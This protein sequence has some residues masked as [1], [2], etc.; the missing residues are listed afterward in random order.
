MG[1]PVVK[2]GLRGLFASRQSATI[3]SIFFVCRLHNMINRSPNELNTT[4]TPYDIIHSNACFAYLNETWGIFE[5]AERNNTPN[6]PYEPIF[7]SIHDA[8]TLT[9]EPSN[10]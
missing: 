6:L 7:R 9:N 4:L 10:S 8:G 2:R 3:R 1:A 5:Q